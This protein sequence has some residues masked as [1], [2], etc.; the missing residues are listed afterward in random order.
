MNPIRRI[1][2]AASFVL[3]TFV[4]LGVMSGLNQLA[5]PDSAAVIQLVTAASAPSV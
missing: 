2:R 3:A 1:H 5:S 4:T